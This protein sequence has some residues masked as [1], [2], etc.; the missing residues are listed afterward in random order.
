M[1]WF[2]F[3]SFGKVLPDQGPAVFS[4]G[5]CMHPGQTRI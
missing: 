1:V 2:D 3:Y 4:G 5:D